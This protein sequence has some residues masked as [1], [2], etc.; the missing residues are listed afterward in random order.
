MCTVQ[1]NTLCK[2]ERS[3][4]LISDVDGDGEPE[5]VDEWGVPLIVEYF[6]GGY[7]VNTVNL[8]SLPD[9]SI[10]VGRQ[11]SPL[12]LGVA[13]NVIRLRSA[14]SDGEFYTADDVINDVMPTLPLI[15]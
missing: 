2:I 7:A 14:G 13:G 5:F 9:G 15:R 4:S 1:S 12:D 10:A 3:S 8:V 11:P 6:R